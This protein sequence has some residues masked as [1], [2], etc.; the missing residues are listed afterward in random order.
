LSD[1]ISLS[2][3]LVV[4]IDSHVGKIGVDVGIIGADVGKIDVH[5]VKASFGESVAVS[6]NIYLT[7]EE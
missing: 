7:L 1:D 3:G 4:I 2:F 6:R 5:V